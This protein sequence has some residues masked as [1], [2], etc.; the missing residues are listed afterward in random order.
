M[1]L[2]YCARRSLPSKKLTQKQSNKPRSSTT[3]EDGS[4]TSP[5]AQDEKEEGVQDDT[6]KDDQNESNTP[7]M[8]KARGIDLRS[9]SKNKKKRRSIK[10]KSP[11]GTPSM[12]STRS[13]R[14]SIE[15]LMSQRKPRKSMK[16][17]MHIEIDPEVDSLGFGSANSGNDKRMERIEKMLNT[18]SD[19][20][21]LLDA[22]QVSGRFEVGGRQSRH[23]SIS[24]RKRNRYSHEDKRR[25]ASTSSVG[26]MGNIFANID[27]L[28]HQSQ[29]I[30]RNR[31]SV[32]SLKHE[33]AAKQGERLVVSERRTRSSHVAGAS[34]EALPMLSPSAAH[35]GRN[36]VSPT[37]KADSSDIH[38]SDDKVNV[39]GTNVWGLS[40][41]GGSKVSPG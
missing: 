30:T 38:D 20:I 7:V 11:R 14:A 39:A 8:S 12:E 3:H 17:N 10:R 41:G 26:S 21:V 13:N 36:L 27:E 25:R 33:E 19:Q 29:R 2:Q 5:A 1:Q 37:A 40:A 22:K 6:A 15:K 28:E 4:S 34:K 24:D 31:G 16:S 32:Q 9:R 23:M 18:L 35:S